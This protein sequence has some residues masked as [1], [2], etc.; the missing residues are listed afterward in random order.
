MPVCADLT[1]AHG[2][3]GHLKES[4]ELFIPRIAP[5][6][7]DAQGRHHRSPG[8]PEQ[9]VIADIRPNSVWSEAQKKRR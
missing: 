6:I 3:G 7:G 4:V 8:N 2:V 9:E 1:P 5:L